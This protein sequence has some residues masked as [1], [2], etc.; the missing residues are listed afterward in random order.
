MRNSLLGPTEV[1]MGASRAVDRSVSHSEIVTIPWSAV[2]E[3]RLHEACDGEADRGDALEFWGQ[4]YEGN[5]WRVHLRRK[6][7][8]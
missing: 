4:D 5:N 3:A 2:T 7:E 8:E 1:T 6:S